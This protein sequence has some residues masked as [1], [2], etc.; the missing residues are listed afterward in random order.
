MKNEAGPLKEFYDKVQR[1]SH[2]IVVAY[3]SLVFSTL[4]GYF[5][6]PIL[7]DVV[8]WLFGRTD[9]QYPFAF[10]ANFLIFDPRQNTLTFVIYSIVSRLYANV[11]LYGYFIMNMFFWTLSFY[12]SSY[13]ESVKLQLRHL[14][15]EG[16]NMNEEEETSLLKSVVENHVIAVKMVRSMDEVVRFNML[17]QFVLLTFS[18]CFVLFNLR[19]VSCCIK[20][21]SGLAPRA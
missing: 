13:L 18:F 9:L 20:C 15:R 16:D 17:T 3:I 21:I 19:Y 7:I 12:V 14:A 8:K 4:V 2:R 5:Y 1:Q 11:F 6:F 10:K